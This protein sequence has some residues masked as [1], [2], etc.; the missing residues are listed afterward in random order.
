MIPEHGLVPFMTYLFSIACIWIFF[1]SLFLWTIFLLLCLDIP[2]YRL[3][4][5]FFFLDF[6][7]FCSLFSL[8][9]FLPCHSRPC[10]Y[11]LVLW[12]CFV[13]NYITDDFFFY[14]H[15]T[16][17]TQRWFDLVVPKILALIFDSQISCAYFCFHLQ[18]LFFFFS[19]RGMHFDTTF[20]R[21]VIPSYCSNGVIYTYK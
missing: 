13:S 4:F 6:F 2:F 20:L 11:E 3:Y 5:G 7:F 10:Y 18:K 15:Q 12:T 1:G 9:L 17:K 16:R 21:T 19:R 8:T 14:P